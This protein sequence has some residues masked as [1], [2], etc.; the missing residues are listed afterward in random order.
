MERPGSARLLD[1]TGTRRGSRLDNEDENRSLTERNIHAAGVGGGISAMASRN[2][3]QPRKRLGVCF[4]VHRR[5]EALLRGVRDERPHILPAV[6]ASGCTKRV[7]WHTFRRSFA[8]LM[9]DRQEDIKV[10][11]ELMRH[12]SSTL[13]L[14][15]YQQGA[16]AAKRLALTHSA[17]IFTGSAS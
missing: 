1:K 17:S 7:G 9:G 11:Q 15:I 5:R 6:R 10:V 16:V 4:T 14:D 2:S 12:S 13:T 8:C 3:P